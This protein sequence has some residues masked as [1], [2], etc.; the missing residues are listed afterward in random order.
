MMS[1]IPVQKAQFILSRGLRTTAVLPVVTSTHGKPAVKTAAGSFD[2]KDVVSNGE[3]T[4]TWK[5][6][7]KACNPACR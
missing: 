4:V 7:V 6:D 2:R 5:L 3:V 1:S